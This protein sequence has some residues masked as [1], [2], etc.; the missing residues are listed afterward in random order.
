MPPLTS[1]LKGDSG[2]LGLHGGPQWLERLLGEP[3]VL[4]LEVVAFSGAVVDLEMHAALPSVEYE[5]CGLPSPLQ[6]AGSHKD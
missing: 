1:R 2:G 5:L 6:R 3:A 4:L